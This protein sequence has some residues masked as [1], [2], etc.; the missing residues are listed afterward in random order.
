[1]VNLT[2]FNVFF[3]EKREFFLEG[4][5]I[6]AFGGV[7]I[8]PRPGNVFAAASNTPVL[9]FS[10]Q[11]GLQNGRPVP[12]RWGGRLTGKA[13]GTSIGLLDIETGPSTLAGATCSAA[14]RSGSW[15]R[16]G[17]RPWAWT[18]RTSRS[19]RTRP[20]PSSST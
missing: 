2:R 11:I 8:V 3:P 6:F 19:A 9:F 14:A 4:Q 20:S 13:G 7:E 16:G 18:A 10:R 1:V 15:P 12:I 17:R 5:G